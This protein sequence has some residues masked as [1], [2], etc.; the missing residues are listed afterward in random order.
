[1]IK[2]RLTGVDVELLGL[3]E[4][5]AYLVEKLAVHNN[6]NALE[7]WQVI[8]GARQILKPMSIQSTRS[9]IDY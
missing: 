6:P 1:M 3:N 2:F 4:A 8:K 9:K 5:S 7:K